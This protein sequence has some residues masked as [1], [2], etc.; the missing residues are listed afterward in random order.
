MK[1]VAD[2]N[3]PLVREAFQTL[4]D[5]VTLPGRKLTREAL[6]D[7]D[8]LMVRSVTKANAA[9]LEG[10]PVRFVATATIGLDHLDIPYLNERGIVFASAPGSNAESVAQYIASALATLAERGGFSL[11]QKT[12][13]I[14][15]VGN[16][17]SRVERVAKALGLKVILNDPPLERKTG[18]VRRYRPLKEIFEA[19]LITTHVPLEKKGPEA[20]WHLANRDFF[21]RMKPGAMYLNSSRGEVH[22]TAALSHALETK[23]L[24]QVVLDVWEGEPSPEAALVRR[25]TLGTPHIAGYGFD[26]KIRGTEMIYQAACRFLGVAESWSP[27]PLID[28]PKEA[29]FILD[30]TGLS[31]DDLCRRFVRKIYDIQEDDK[32]FKVLAEKP[33]AEQGAYFDQLRKSYPSR[34]EFANYRVRLTG[35]TA[36]HEAALAG[37]GAK[38]ER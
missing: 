4:G 20:T 13:G 35:G 23:Q 3:I 11:A 25:V 16:V 15:G 32:R 38:V 6:A 5:V 22:D 34:R 7:A 19:D 8:L 12:L 21:G 10:T 24:S 37:L 18:D 31:T 14:I 17:G 33:A 26:G 29:A 28:P 9:L 27:W 30:A 1:I 2:E 36:A